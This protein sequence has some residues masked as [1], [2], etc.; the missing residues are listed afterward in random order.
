MNEQPI[1]SAPEPYPKASRSMK[2]SAVIGIAIAVLIIGGGGGFYSGMQYEK[3][4]LKKNP[5]QLFTA[6]GIGS[7]RQFPGGNTNRAFRGGAFG[8]GV[9]GQPFHRAVLYKVIE[10][11][12][13][14]NQRAYERY[15]SILEDPRSKEAMVSRG[16]PIRFNDG[17]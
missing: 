10:R 1:Q 4:T 12:A 6:N 17:N 14:R 3:Q 9:R 16:A 11:F 2:Q 7:A 8:G 13:L 5:Q 15:R